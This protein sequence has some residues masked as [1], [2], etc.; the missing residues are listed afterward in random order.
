MCDLVLLKV[1][2]ILSFSYY[3]ISNEISIMQGGMSEYFTMY[4]ITKSDNSLLVST[5]ACPNP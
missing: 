1:V 3:N 2:V 5:G 4:F